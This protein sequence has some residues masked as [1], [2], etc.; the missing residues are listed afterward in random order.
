MATKQQTQITFDSG[1]NQEKT[2][3]GSAWV[4]S[5]AVTFDAADWAGAVTA[6]ADN[7]DTPASGHTVDVG[8]LYT[9]GNVDGS[10]GNDYVNPDNFSLVAQLDTYNNDD[11][12]GVVSVSVPLDVAR[13]L[14]FKLCFRRNAGGATGIKVRALINTNR[15]A[16]V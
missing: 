6:W 8:V 5:D 13:H 2:L 7:L 14:G 3:T 1:A 16:V 11:G 12:N 10:A 4:V 15:G 9:D